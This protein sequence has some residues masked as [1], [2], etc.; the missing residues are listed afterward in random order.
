MGTETGLSRLRWRKS[1][2]SADKSGNCV[3]CAPRNGAAWR[4]SSHSGHYDGNCVEVS[5]ECAAGVAIRDSK[6]PDGPQLEVPAEAFAA[7]VAAQR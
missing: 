2:Y 5:P 4:K 7:F 3:E 1:S 6:R